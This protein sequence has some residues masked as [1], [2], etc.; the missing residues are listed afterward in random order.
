MHMMNVTLA[1]L[2]ALFLFVLVSRLANRDGGGAGGARIFIWVWLVA[3]AANG[4]VGVVRAGISPL[5]EIGVFFVVFGI[6]AASAWFAA[7]RLGTQQ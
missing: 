1:G 5:V 4:I 2:A 7:R 6:P 3:A